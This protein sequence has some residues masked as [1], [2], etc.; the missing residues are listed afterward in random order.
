MKKILGIIVGVLLVFVAIGVAMQEAIVERMM[1]NIVAQNL[2]RDVVRDLPDG[3]HVFV[4]GAGSPMPNP[5]AGGP[6]LV[7]IAGQDVYVVDAGTGGSRTMALGGVNPGAVKG[8]FLTHFHSDH[9]DGLGEMMLQRWVGGTHS[10]PLPVYGPVGVGTIVDGFN[11]AYTPDFGYRVAHHG[12]DIVPRSG[13]G[14]SAVSFAVPP[15]GQA[16]TVLEEGGLTVIAFSVDHSP[17]S[18]AVGYRFDYKGRSVTI[19]GDT[20]KSANLEKFAQGTDLLM[21]EG[22]AANLVKIM[23]HSARQAGR[24]NLAKI[25]FDI[26]DYHA[27]PVEAAQSAETAGAKMLGFYHIVPPLLVKPME[28]LFLRG[29]EDAYSGPVVVSTDGTFYHMPAGTD[30]VS[31]D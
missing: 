15:Q 31:V 4:C 10:A 30:D 26:Q 22:L 6:C 8:L 16:V 12:E 18:P 14:G 13:A 11:M 5:N 21:H 25:F 23:E 24:D 3:L 9:I 1:P 20:A 2:E 7:V 27:T 19:S 17:V 29:V 28:G